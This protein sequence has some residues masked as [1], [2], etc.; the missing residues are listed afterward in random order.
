MSDLRSVPMYNIHD[1]ICIDKLKEFRKMYAR[2]YPKD[3][4][5]YIPIIMK[6]LSLT[7]NEFPMF[8]GHVNYQTDKDGYI[9]DYIERADHN[10]A[11]AIDTPAGLVVPNIK[12]V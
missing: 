10:I 11:I 5:T 4:I 9:S 2:L 8:N 7:I 12:Q 6:A 3:K 1:D